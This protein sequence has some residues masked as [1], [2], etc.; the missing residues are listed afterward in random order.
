MKRIQV[1]YKVDGTMARD[2]DYAERPRSRVS[3]KGRGYVRI[4]GQL[5]LYAQVAR[6]RVT[7]VDE[8]GDQVD[9]S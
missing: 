8:P 4:P 7:E 6:I 2:V 3:K 5:S 1:D 9:M